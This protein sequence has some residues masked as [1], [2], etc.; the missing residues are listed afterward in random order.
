MQEFEINTSQ[1][2]A[3]WKRWQETIDQLPGLKEA[4]LEKL[5]GRVQGEVRG[6]VDRSGLN[7]SRGRVK[8]WQNPH[9]GSGLGY[10]AVR[11]D[12]VE[13]AAG[14]RDR[15]RLNAGALTNFLSSG[16]KVRGPSGR[17]ESYQPRARMTRVKGYDFYAKA[18]AEAEKIA[19]QEAEAFLERLTV[20]ELKL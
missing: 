8:R 16:H 7:D 4:M 14:Y 15:Q 6:A 18:Q 1:W 10:V 19:V 20:T 17:A 12:S 13:A 9:V 3:F 5:G 2:T 11:A